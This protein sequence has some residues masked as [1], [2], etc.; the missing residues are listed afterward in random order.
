MLHGVGDDAGCGAGSDGGGDDEGA[1]SEGGG[2]DEGA[3]DDV[4]ELPPPSD[5]HQPPESLIQW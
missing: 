1:G 5:M 4:D 2:D 3:G